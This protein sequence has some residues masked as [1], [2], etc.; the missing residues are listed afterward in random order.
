MLNI[1]LNKREKIPPKN[2]KKKKIIIIKKKGTVF[3]YNKLIMYS[4]KRM[5]KNTK[6]VGHVHCIM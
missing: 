5:T 4:I 3:V 6:Y 1:V 2:I